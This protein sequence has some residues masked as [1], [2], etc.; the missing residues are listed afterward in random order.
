MSDIIWI[1]RWSS[2]E[3]SSRDVERV[4]AF[5][6]ATL[7]EGP[8]LPERAALILTDGDEPAELA[9]VDGPRCSPSEFRR[10]YGLGFSPNERLAALRRVAVRGLETFECWPFAL[11]LLAGCEDEAERH[12][13][14]AE[15]DALMPDIPPQK[16]WIPRGA[17]DDAMA[18]RPAASTAGGL[19]V[20]YAERDRDRAERLL[21]DPSC[22][23]YVRELAL[24]G[25]DPAWALD[26]LRRLT[27]RPGLC[28]DLRHIHAS[29]WKDRLAALPADCGGVDLEGSDGGPALFEDLAA[30]PA[31][32]EM[33]TLRAHRN[34][35][36]SAGLATLLRA[37]K[38]RGI[39]E[40]DL[41]NND[42]TSKDFAALADAPWLDGVRTLKVK[43]NNARVE[44]AL[45]LLASPR[46]HALEH[47]DIGANEIGDVG[48]AAL[49]DNP[50]VTALKHLACEGNK[51][52]P[53]ITLDGATALGAWPG[54]ASLHTLNLAMNKLG[55]KGIA[56]LVAGPQLS[57]VRSLDVQ[58]CGATPSL[59]KALAG[60]ESPM[61]PRA[62]NLTGNKLGKAR[63]GDIP[64]APQLPRKNPWADARWLS[65]CVWL[66]LHNTSLD[67]D[68]LAQIVC[69]PA[70]EKVRWLSLSGN[71]G[72]GSAAL[73]FLLASP[74][75]RGL[76]GLSLLWC[77]LSSGDGAALANAPFA[78][79]LLRLRVSK[80]G[81][82][83]ADVTALRRTYGPRLE[84]S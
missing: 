19:L 6:G 53:L 59:A 37:R 18:G 51:A 44:G 23:P 17:L 67:A 81:L 36:N 71:N 58:Y 21:A 61:R 82:D 55:D 79:T 83:E 84:L 42:L 9:A 11:A 29:F 43:Y 80:K 66:E 3:V 12:A 10:R 22:A 65:E 47:L 68:T 30:H 46:L 20:L 60:V 49:F 77:P 63:Y 34:R 76:D 28:I 41:G 62:V 52:R 50:A 1:Q 78:A 4:R 57:Q 8:T 2:G 35:A 33:R 5:E 16:R 32:Q 26:V 24:A 38:A 54:A 40:L 13:L 31:W 45:A 39:T 72:L 7:H 69:S 56:A 75:A 70:L 74:I 15:A 25:G 14:A 48:L 27:G 73:R 64:A